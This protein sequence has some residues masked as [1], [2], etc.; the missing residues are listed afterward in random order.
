MLT[1]GISLKD[2]VFNHVPSSMIALVVSFWAFAPSWLTKNPWTFLGVTL[3]ILITVLLL[4]QLNERHQSW[5]L[6]KRE[7]FTDT[8]YVILSTSVISWLTITLVEDPLLTTK[9]ALGL[10]THWIAAL[11]FV[12]QVLMVIVIFEFGQYWMH[13]L[14]HNW[15]P[16]WLTHA[17]HHHMTQLNAFKGYVGNPI[18]LFL[19]SVGVIALFDFK[20]TAVFCAFNVTG[21]I[22]SFAHSNVRADPPIWYSYIFTT[23][24]HHS[25]HH[26]ADYDATRSNFGNSLILLDRIFGTY[27]EGE[28]VI[29]G[30]GELR[31]L[32]IWEQT[33][34][35]FQP[36]IDAYK[37]RKTVASSDR[38]V[39]PDDPAPKSNQAGDIAPA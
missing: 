10:S 37:R 29:L 25:L 1:Q 33:M 28:G 34:F 18:E 27:R 22:S 24:R 6:N 7:F 16:A 32:S 4:E 9:A 30:Q 19:I 13:R 8:Y 20:D 12:I 31:R 39:Q 14:M 11:P 2:R 26:S 38:L 21:V 35:P 5:R 15:H 3:L 23:I 36:M 17:P